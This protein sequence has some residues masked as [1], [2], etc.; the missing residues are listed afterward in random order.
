MATFSILV[1][2]L[3]K[4]S[5]LGEALEILEQMHGVIRE[6]NV[7]ADPGAARAAATEEANRPMNLEELQEELRRREALLQRLHG[8][9][10]GCTDQW[11]VYREIC[12]A[13]GQNRAPLRMFLQASAGT[14]KSF[15]LE[16]V[17]LWAQ[18]QG[19][20]VEACAPTGIA[21]ARIRVER[22]P[23]R[24][25]IAV[26]GDSD[27]VASIKLHESLGFRMVGTL[28]GT[29]FKFDRWVD[30]VIMQKPRN[31]ISPA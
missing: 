15:L 14:G 5:T 1:K 2:V 31:G 24:Q 11:R 27:Y 17:F 16:T 18:I 6:S 8:E 21:A 19:H 26:I 9:D 29:G 3:G 12:D 10:G 25:M 30:T 22:T 7:Y 20:E 4:G 23:V 13:L 28:K